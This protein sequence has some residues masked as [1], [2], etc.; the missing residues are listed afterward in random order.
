MSAQE[1]D[2]AEIDES[3]IEGAAKNILEAANLIDKLSDTEGREIVDAGI[4][5]ILRDTAKDIRDYR[6]ASSNPSLSDEQ[7]KRLRT[8]Y[9]EAV[10]NGAIFLGRFSFFFTVI[11]VSTSSPA[12]LSNVGSLASILGLIEIGKPGSIY[13]IYS[14]FRKALPLLPAL[15]KPKLD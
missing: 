9:V 4:P 7:A 13:W 5:A 1:I 12:A 3:Q 14:K 6:E 2:S 8:R 15:P 11:L 10:K